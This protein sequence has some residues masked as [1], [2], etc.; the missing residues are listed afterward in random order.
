MHMK[1][2]PWP[3]ETITLLCTE[4]NH[5]FHGTK[6]NWGKKL[7]ETCPKCGSKKIIEAPFLY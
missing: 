6:P 4:C 3:G 1:R 2:M 5:H 7:K